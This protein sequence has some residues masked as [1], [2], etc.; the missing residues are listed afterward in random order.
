MI[1]ISQLPAIKLYQGTEF[2]PIV[3][4]GETRKAL[5]IFADSSLKVNIPENASIVTKVNGEV[6]NLISA[7]VVDG[8]TTVMIGDKEVSLYKDNS[9]IVTES[10]TN[11]G[12]FYGRTNNGW[13][14][15]NP[16]T[17]INHVQAPTGGGSISLSY[18][19]VD[20]H[21]NNTNLDGIA[22][23]SQDGEWVDAKTIFVPL[24]TAI[25][26]QKADKEHTHEID[27]INLLRD[28]LGT[29]EH[30]ADKEHTHEIS[31]VNNLQI[32]LNDIKNSIPVIEVPTIETVTGLSDALSDINAEIA[33]KANKEHIHEISDIQNLQPKLEQ[34]DTEISTT[35]SNITKIRDEIN[36]PFINAKHQ[37]VTTSDA[38]GTLPLEEVIGNKMSIVDNALVPSESGIYFVQFITDIDSDNTTVQLEGVQG[39]VTD[40]KGN[41]VRAGIFQLEKDGKY[42]LKYTG[43]D[44]IITSSI[45]AYKL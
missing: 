32:E 19:D 34:I 28:A 15:K 5:P 37:L 3:Q 27:D 8:V 30:K 25:T 9:I 26:D 31:D 17:Q 23:V 16:I 10:E 20:A 22:Y 38:S 12:N 42:S 13:V 18:S 29:I 24:I 35:K 14:I 45:I 44:S 36:K 7:V 4:E 43:Q 1:K 6:I 2:T 33:T 21:K 41:S 40:T 11:D 39:L